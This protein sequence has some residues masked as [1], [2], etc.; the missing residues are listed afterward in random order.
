[1]LWLVRENGFLF[2]A[3][4]NYYAYKEK[5]GWEDW[6]KNV[7][8]CKGKAFLLVMAIARRLQLLLMKFRS[9]YKKF[10]EFG[11]SSNSKGIRVDGHLNYSANEESLVIR[12]RLPMLTKKSRRIS[13]GIANWVAF[14]HPYVN[15]AEESLV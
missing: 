14:F 6:A 8:E 4:I 1:M 3:S 13:T 11:A 12:G 7:I 5:E 10:R 15:Y 9:T 2:E